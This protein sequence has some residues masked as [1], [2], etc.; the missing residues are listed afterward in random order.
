M[1]PFEFHNPTRII[2]G[3]G[4][5][6]QAGTEAAKIGGRALIVTGRRSAEK[7]GLLDKVTRLLRDEG[8][9]VFHLKGVDPNPRL[10]SVAQGVEICR[11]NSVDLVI[12]LGGGSSMDT[13]K[14]VAAG[15]FYE[16][17]LWD[18]LS[19]GQP[20]YCPPGKALPIMMI[21]TLAATGSEMNQNAVI[22]NADTTEKCAIHAPC[23]F[24]RVSIVDPAL[25]CSVPPDHTAYGA[26]DTV[27]HSLEP[28][29]NGVDDTP[30]QNYMQEA[31]MLTAIENAP[32]ALAAPDDVAVRANL[33]WASI[34]SL[35]HLNMAGC[36]SGFPMHHIEHA[37]SAHYDVP[38]GAGL[39][40]VSSAFMKY[41]HPFR[42]DR[43]V[44]FAESLFGVE[45]AGRES[46]G[47]VLEGIERFEEFIK[48]IGCPTRL[49]DLDVPGAGL[50]AVIAT[51]LRNYGR[52]QGRVRGR[53][54]LGRDALRSILELAL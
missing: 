48:S 38:H 51:T 31:A 12:G 28:Y 40:V 6:E 10:T 24:P 42:P 29:L 34:L 21:P 30:A 1:Q 52:D 7:F 2:F 14:A 53:P 8:V 27:I 22:T 3:P 33:Q 26:L 11:A 45:P 20:D 18:M 19:H 43:Y 25:T 47:V 44:R 39:A 32:K 37:L 35:N 17:E 46:A 16:G 41:A 4:V 36:D 9:G 5:V 15:V 54:P 23:L 49:S 50:D 13:A